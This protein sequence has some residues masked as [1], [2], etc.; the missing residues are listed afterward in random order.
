M[1]KKS[2]DFMVKGILLS[3]VLMVISLIGG[4]AH[5]QFETW[6][7]WL[8]TIIQVVVIIIFCIQYGN[9]QTDG[10]TF[11]KVFGYGFK[12]SLVISIL[13][14]VYAL[15]SLFIIFP[16]FTDQALQQARAGMEAKG[17][18]TEDQI[19]KRME[20]TKKFMQPVPIAIFAFLGTLFFGT[21]ASLLGAAFA[22]KSEPE[23]AIFKDNP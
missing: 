9:Q 15:L 1:K 3:L 23:P 22:K 8:P 19:D 17:N 11:G 21:I 18:L 10:V 14:I 16:E 5:L 20:I 6:F 4:F 7:K 2:T 13:M 12:I